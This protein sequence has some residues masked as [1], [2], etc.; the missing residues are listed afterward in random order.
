METNSG[1]SLE[2]RSLGVRPSAAARLSSILTVE[3]R[4][5]LRHG[6]ALGAA[7]FETDLDRQNA[8]AGLLQNVN[9]AF[10][11]GNDAEFC[12]KKPRADDGM[13]GE[14]QFFLRSENAQAGERAVFGRFLDEDGF[15]EIHFAGDGVHV[16]LER[17]SPSVMTARGLPSKRVVVKT[18]SV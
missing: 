14:F 2:S 5:F 15:G 11:R 6:H 10:L 18:S 3:R 12:E 4:F 8:G 16:V 1:S 9:A 13:A 17:P 7:F